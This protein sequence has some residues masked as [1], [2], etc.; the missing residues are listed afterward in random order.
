M[1]RAAL[2]LLGEATPLQL[3]DNLHRHA[4]GLP[5]GL[6]DADVSPTR[7]RVVRPDTRHLATATSSM[8]IAR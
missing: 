6:I 4:L 2:R 8:R 5:P 7:S 3:T 1:H